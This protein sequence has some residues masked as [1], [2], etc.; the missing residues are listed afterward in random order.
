MT[1]GGDQVVIKD[2]A[3]EG[4]DITGGFMANSFLIGFL[5][6][7]IVTGCT[8]DE[9][10]KMT[11][12]GDYVQMNGGLVG[13]AQTSN[14]NLGGEIYIE[15]CT[16]N[17][18]ISGGMLTGGIAGA[19]GQRIVSCTNNGSVSAT[20]NAGGIVGY[21]KEEGG[22]APVSNFKLCEPWR[23]FNQ[24]RLGRAD[25]RRSYCFRR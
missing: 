8:V 7:A 16:N 10:S 24:I 9:T 11:V 25:R 14:L 12:N 20:M 13:G 15:N 2:V 22:V 18:T 6:E 5:S 23:C 1:V 17:G 19:T 21:Y 3:I 4:A